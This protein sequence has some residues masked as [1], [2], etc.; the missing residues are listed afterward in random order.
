MDFSLLRVVGRLVCA[1]L[2]WFLFGVRASEVLVPGWTSPLHA[3]RFVRQPWPG[4]CPKKPWRQETSW[5]EVIRCSARRKTGLGEDT[6]PTR[7][8]AG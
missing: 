3:G 7:P 5:F 6:T 8:F 1:S 4:A 2:L